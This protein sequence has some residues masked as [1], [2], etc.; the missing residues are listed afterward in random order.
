M[1]TNPFGEQ[2]T[3]V[4][5]STEGVWSVGRPTLVALECPGAESRRAS[6]DGEPTDT[7]RFLAATRTRLDNSGVQT[8]S[9]LVD[10]GV[11]EIYQPYPI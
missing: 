3:F 1:S 8:V 7:A 9:I 6:Y 2:T 5:V 10:R 4:Q 11:R